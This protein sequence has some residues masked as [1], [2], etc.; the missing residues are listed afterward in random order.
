MG[1]ARSK[2]G[3]YEQNTNN[4]HTKYTKYERSANKA[5]KKHGHVTQESWN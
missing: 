1:Y 2:H 3:R 4:V 5:Q